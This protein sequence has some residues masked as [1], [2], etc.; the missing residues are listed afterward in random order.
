MRAVH[1]IASGSTPARVRLG[2]AAA[3]LLLAGALTVGVADAAQ[4]KKRPSG[5]SLSDEYVYR[6]KSAS[7]HSFFGQNI[8][9]ECMGADVEVLDET[10]RVVRMIPGAKTLEQIAAQKAVDDARTAAAQRDR[11]LLA[12]YLSV[13]DIE[14]LRDQ[15]ID[16]LEQQNVVTRQY[17]TNLRAR[18]ARLMESV[19][20]FRPYS[21]KPNAS[22]LPEQ[23]ASEI[24]N[25]VKGLQVYEQEL[26]KNTTERERVTQEFAADISRFKELKGIK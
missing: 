19:Q 2:V 6:C 4:K 25:T 23:I 16:L 24:V 22:A 14:R 21:A 26:A 1:L 18:E 15:R 7:G 11:T 20:R 12:T 10:G 17:I 5:K 9:P 8:P 13:A 3:L